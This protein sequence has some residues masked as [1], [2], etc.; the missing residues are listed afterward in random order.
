VKI[1]RKSQFEAVPWKNGGGITHE[2]IRVPPS[3]NDFRWRVSI[4]KID[5]TGPFSDFSG[6]ERHMVLLAGNGLRLCFDDGADV[7]LNAT[8]ALVQFDGSRAPQCELLDGPCTDLNLMVS[9]SLR[10]S[11]VGVEYLRAP[12]RSSA[13]TLLAVPISGRVSVTTAGG[14]PLVIEPRELVILEPNDESVLSPMMEAVPPLVFF[15]TLADNS[16]QYR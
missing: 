3:G 6:Y 4:A 14:Q 12:R 11:G 7:R 2:V 13:G 5:V 9:K 16:P 1:V 10:S 8:G 15:A